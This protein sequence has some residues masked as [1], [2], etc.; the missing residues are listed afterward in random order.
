MSVIILYTIIYYM[1]LIVNDTKKKERYKTAP[2]LVN[3][4]YFSLV[5]DKRQFRMYKSVPQKSGKAA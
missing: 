1:F 2:K 4:Y 5:A 3:S